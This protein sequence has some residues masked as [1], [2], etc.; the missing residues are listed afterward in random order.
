MVYRVGQGREA[1]RQRVNYEALLTAMGQD[2][3]TIN[4]TIRDPFRAVGLD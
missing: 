1:G 3:P 4:Q 2:K